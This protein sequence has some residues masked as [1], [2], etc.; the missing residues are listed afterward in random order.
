MQKTVCW[1][2]PAPWRKNLKTPWV[3]SGYQA[4]TVRKQLDASPYPL[5]ICGD[6]NDVPNSYTYFHIRGKLQD[7]FIA[8]CFGIGRTYMHISPTLRIDYIL[9]SD[10][11]RDRAKHET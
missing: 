7:A 5:V 1:K 9:P 11:F 8:K 2:L 10:E 6:F 4:D 3:C